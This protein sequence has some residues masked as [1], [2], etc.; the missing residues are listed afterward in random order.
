[1]LVSYKNGGDESE[2]AGYEL[3]PGG[4][5]VRSLDPRRLPRP[6]R[7]P[8]KLVQGLQELVHLLRQLEVDQQGQ[9]TRIVAVEYCRGFP[10]Y[11]KANKGGQIERSSTCCMRKSNTRERC[12]QSYRK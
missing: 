10:G 11:G 6:L 8:Q 4:R 12:N 5:T 1:M 7:P 9:E 2:I 3:K